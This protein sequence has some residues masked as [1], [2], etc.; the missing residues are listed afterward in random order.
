MNLKKEMYLYFILAF[1]LTVL[2]FRVANA[3]EESCTLKFV[4]TEFPLIINGTQHQYSEYSQLGTSKLCLVE[5]KTE[6]NF[7]SFT[8]N[9]YNGIFIVRDF[10]ASGF[11]KVINSNMNDKM[12]EVYYYFTDPVIGEPVFETKIYLPLVNKCYTFNE[13]LGCTFPPAH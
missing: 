1:V 2:F 6:N 4:D 10:N 3:Q 9:V 7:Y 12:L 11:G 13:P 8:E 5:V